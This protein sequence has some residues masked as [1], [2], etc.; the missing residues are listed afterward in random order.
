LKLLIGCLSL[1]RPEEDE[2]KSFSPRAKAAKLKEVAERFAAPTTCHPPPALPMPTSAELYKQA[3]ALKREAKW[4]EAIAKLEELL[5]HDESHVLSHLALAVLYGKVGKHH[6]AVQHAERAVE[7]EP[8]DQF[9][10]TALSVT[11]Q[12]AFEATQDRTFIYKAEQAKE[13]SH[14]MQWQK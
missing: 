4:D 9:N 8:T 10:F 12:R 1:S 5:Q 11:Y 6:E 7:L 3:E 2:R 14:M 13:R